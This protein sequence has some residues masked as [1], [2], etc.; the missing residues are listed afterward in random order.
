MLLALDTSTRTMGVCLYDGARVLAELLWTT[1]D[2]H[3]VELAPAVVATLT[4]ADISASDLNVLAVATGPGSFTGLR[5]GLALAKGLSLANHIPII[6]I[7]TLDIIAAAQPLREDKMAAVI[8]A[9]RGRLA[10]GWY[11]VVDGS[12]KIVGDVDVLTPLELN[13]RIRKPTL[14]CGELNEDIRA[15]LGRKRVNVILASPAQSVRRPAYLAELGWQRWLSGR[16]DDPA[17]LSPTYLHYNQR[18]PR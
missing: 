1:Q 15:L 5:I 7:A 2:Y 9:G 4:K 12:W 14:V 17:I 16:V 3:T 11:Q 10:V 13:R 8:Q 18:I 6:G